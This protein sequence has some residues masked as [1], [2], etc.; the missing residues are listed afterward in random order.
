M[1]Q[2]KEEEKNRDNKYDQDPPEHD[3]LLSY[4]KRQPFNALA[5]PVSS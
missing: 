4:L 3:A 2:P 1:E 5:S